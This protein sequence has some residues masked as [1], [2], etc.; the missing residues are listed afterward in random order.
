[1]PPRKRG[2]GRVACPEA[3]VPPPRGLP[4]AIQALPPLTP[5][6]KRGEG[7]GENC[8]RITK[9]IQGW[10]AWLRLRDGRQHVL[11]GYNIVCKAERGL[12]LARDVC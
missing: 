4:T 7:K 2:W 3:P 10:Q 5:P 1:M 8:Q 12:F 11:T 6:Y 9:R